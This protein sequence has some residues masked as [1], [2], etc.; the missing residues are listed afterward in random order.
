MGLNC[1]LISTNLVQTPYPVYPLGIAHLA[2]A[3]EQ[4]GHSV[5]HFDILAS[6]DLKSLESVLENKQFDLIGLSIRNLDTTDSS[7][8]ASFIDHA[9]DLMKIVRQKSNSPVVIGGPA[10]SIFPEEIFSLLKPDYGVVGEGEKILPEIADSLCNDKPF[11][12][13]IVRADEKICSWKPVSYCK[14]IADYYLKWGGMLNIQT[15]RGCPNKCIYCSYPLL[16]GKKIRSRDPEE[17]AAEVKRLTRD[18]GAK[19][20]FFAD[21]VFN[22]H[23]DHYLRLTKAL[24]KSGNKTPWCAFF[25]PS[26]LSRNK[27]AYMKQSGLAAMELGTDA[28]SDKT[29][30]GLRKKISFADVLN[31]NNAAAKE[32]VPVA[33]F[34]IFGGPGENKQT[35]GEG[36]KNIDRLKN[37][38]V[39]G[40]V[41]IRILPNTAIY[42]QALL[43]GTCNPD[44]LLEPFF[45]YSP[46]INPKEINRTLKDAWRGRFDRIYPLVELQSRVTRLHQKGY[47]GPMWDFLI[48]R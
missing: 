46:E 23:E 34:V 12:K 21:A 45:Y 47:V 41:G 1:L 28:S 43:E 8:P 15:K 2:G 44:N 11:Q 5:V 36:I 30:E 20:I 48:K 32:K 25:Q 22:D 42:E 4:A 35:L 27:I 29:L 16:E 38:V 17:V 26:N 31:T 14:P 6:S 9:P 13:G 7:D 40:C 33:H 37:S 19:Y 10:F 39:F 24:I 3:L 18:F